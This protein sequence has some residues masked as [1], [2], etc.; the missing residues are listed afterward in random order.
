MVSDI[1]TQHETAFKNI[2]AFV[3]CNNKGERV[4]TI[5]FKFG[6]AVTCYLH[7]IGLTMTKGRANGGGYDRKS[8]AIHHAMQ[9]VG[10]G[11]MESKEA[12]RYDDIVA[13]LREALARGNGP[14]SWDS[15]LREAGYNVFQAV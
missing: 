13:A 14:S 3:V 6:N 9:K 11:S 5:A 8:A 12:A 10:C 1:Y 7:I 15:A 2:A 4:A